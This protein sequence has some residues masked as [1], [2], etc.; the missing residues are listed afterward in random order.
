M[1]Q[2]VAQGESAS[3]GYAARKH[4]SP[5]TRATRL[6]HAYRTIELNN[7]LRVNLNHNV[8]LA[9]ST[10]LYRQAARTRRISESNNATTHRSIRRLLEVPSKRFESHA[11]EL[12]E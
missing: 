11:S 5:R 2:R 1:R 6:T 7:P 4:K 10:K 3:P 12:F 8:S 9:M